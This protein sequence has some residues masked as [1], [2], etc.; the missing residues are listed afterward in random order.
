M[1]IDPPANGKIS[2][3]PSFF[4]EGNWL[5]TSQENSSTSQFSRWTDS[6]LRPDRVPAE[7]DPACCALRA[8]C[9]ATHIADIAGVMVTR[10]TLAV[11][12]YDLPS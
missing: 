11:F 9:G 12:E 4:K 3:G 7:S 10:N 5:E 8:T 1:G 6:Q 2:P